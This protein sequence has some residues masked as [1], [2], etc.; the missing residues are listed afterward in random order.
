MPPL[1]ICTLVQYSSY[2]NIVHKLDKNRLQCKLMSKLFLSNTIPNQQ[3]VVINVGVKKSLIKTLCE[4]LF[5]QQK[6]IA[7]F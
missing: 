7:K 4:V 6:T 5:F 2:F 1:K 3:N